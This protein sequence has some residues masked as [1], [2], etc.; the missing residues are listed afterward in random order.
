MSSHVCGFQGCRNLVRDTEGS[1]CHL[2][3]HSRD[4]SSG[5]LANQLSVPDLQERSHQY[6]RARKSPL[7]MRRLAWPPDS[8]GKEGAEFSRNNAYWDIFVEPET[9]AKAYEAI[10]R[11]GPRETRDDL[12]RAM[13]D[14]AVTR[15]IAELDRIMPGRVTKA[16][17]TGLNV[18]V[19]TMSSHHPDY[20]YLVAVVDLGREGECVIDPFARALL[21]QVPVGQNEDGSPSSATISP[22]VEAFRDDVFIGTVQDYVA[23]EGVKWD[24]V[25]FYPASS[26]ARGG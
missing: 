26:A 16:H 18:E 11:I 24:R 9:V 19:G 8:L 15:F 20:R 7:F 22:G 25:E 5:P 2:H 23:R 10:D 21:P 4:E 1:R 17:L 3:R 14:G 13:R 6:L 12:T